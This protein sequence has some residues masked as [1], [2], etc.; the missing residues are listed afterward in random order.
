MVVVRLALGQAQSPSVDQLDR[1][2]TEARDT[3]QTAAESASTEQVRA[4]PSTTEPAR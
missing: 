3:E 2:D 1:A 4:E